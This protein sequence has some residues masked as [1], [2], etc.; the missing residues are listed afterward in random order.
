MVS[1]VNDEIYYLS[2]VCDIKEGAIEK[3]ARLVNSKQV[4]NSRYKDYLNQKKKY[5]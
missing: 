4:L 3:L 2:R 5:R 1:N